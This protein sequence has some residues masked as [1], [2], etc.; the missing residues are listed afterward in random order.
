[1]NKSEKKVLANN[2]K[3]HHDYFLEEI[4]E[5]GIVLTGTEVKSVKQGKVS[6]KEAY[7]RIKDGEA[8]VYNM[9]IAPYKEG[10]IFNVDEKRTRKLLLHKR[11]IRKLIGKTVEKGYTLVPIAVKLSNGL[12]KVDIALATGKKKYDKRDDLIKKDQERQISRALKTR[13]S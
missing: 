10:N 6:V 2:K 4:Y 9:H 8:F 5:A 13:W 12:V 7:C 11:E 3:A 1:M